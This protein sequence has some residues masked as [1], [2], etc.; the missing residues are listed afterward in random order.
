MEKQRKVK[1][2]AIIA[3]FVAVCGMTLGFAAFSKV[4]TI[5]SKAIVVPDETKFSIVASGSSTDKTPGGEYNL[6]PTLVGFTSEEAAEYIELNTAKVIN[7]EQ[8]TISVN[9]SFFRPGQSA[10]YILY[11]HNVG[12]YDIY[13]KSMT[14]NNPEGT[15][16]SKVCKPIEGEEID[17]NKLEQICDE[18][19]LKFYALK[20]S[21]QGSFWMPIESNMT[22]TNEIDL[23][24][25][26]SGMGKAVVEY[27]E[28]ATPIDVPFTVEFSSIELLYS[29]NPA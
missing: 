4:L 21:Q 5:E 11:I 7:G 3:L 20:A 17:P 15:E 28:G 9:T 10:E 23:F 6:I 14:F 2:L 25:G 1:I 13:L 16:M 26:Q 24:P 22:L 19:K 18:I 29:T 8:T 27:G 12:E